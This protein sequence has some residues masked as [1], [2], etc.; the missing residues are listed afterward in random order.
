M[1]LLDEKI[2]MMKFLFVAKLTQP[3]GNAIPYHQ[4]AFVLLLK[5]CALNQVSM[6]PLFSVGLDLSNEIFWLLFLIPKGE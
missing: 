2:I 4:N 3:S 5:A 6:T 1:E